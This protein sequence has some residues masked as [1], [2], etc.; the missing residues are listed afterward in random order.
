MQRRLF[1]I[2]PSG[3][4]KSSLIRTVLGEKLAMAGGLATRPSLS[5]DGAFLGFELLP[6]AALAGVQGLEA[7]RFLY[8]EGTRALH[9]NEAYRQYG[10]RLLQEAAW[11]P[12]AVLDELGGFEL[13]IPQFR[14]ALEELLHADLPVLGALKT[15]E[16]AELLREALG[17]GGRMLEQHRLLCEA[18]EQDADTLLL[19][20]DAPGDPGAEEAVRAW[21]AQHAS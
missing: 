10:V 13:I 17:L 3:C 8:F 19:R 14:A 5:A 4:G 15:A 2:G 11:Y 12:F 9:D 7:R 20:V 16:E 6:P 21:A 1:L 18:L